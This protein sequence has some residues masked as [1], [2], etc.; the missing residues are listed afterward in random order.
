MRN[1]TYSTDDY[2]YKNQKKLRK[3]L[4]TGTCAAACARAAME[5][6]L[7][8]EELKS[9]SVRLPDGS[10]TGDI[11]VIRRAASAREAVFAV[12]KD[13]GDDPDVTNGTEICV[14]ARFAD[15]N[16][17]K[18]GSGRYRDSEDR[19]LFLTGGEGVGT[20]TA[21]G[22]EQ[23]VGMPAINR[24]PREMIFQEAREVHAR[25]RSLLPD[26]FR[27]MD[28]DISEAM[29]FVPEDTGEQI[30]LTV[31]VPEGRHLAEKTFNPV[32]GIRDGISILGTSGIVMP[33]SEKAIV[34]TTALCLKK[35]RT[36]KDQVILVPGNYGR[37]YAEALPGTDPESIVQM[38]NFIGEALDQCVSCAFHRI[39]IVGNIGKL[40]KLSAGIMNTHSRTADARWETMAAHLALQGASREEIAA[41]RQCSTTEE[42][43]TVLE[44][45]GKRKAVTDSLLDAMAGYVERRLG[46]QIPF[47]IILFSERFG[48]LG[49]TERN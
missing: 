18:N 22:L 16:D 49:R 31:S 10:V 28:E 3:G 12:I 15:D 7:F 30:L 32:L 23:A 6:L 24:V 21:P 34:D 37:H 11:P 36:V 46:G 13:A 42:M 40:I 38:S 14:S 29:F 27:D 45:N 1:M 5:M 47:S 33:M 44:Q 8:G 9:V 41:I 17:E 2:I 48:E 4:T 35:L 19:A 26:A 39:T 43:L 20:V 25:Y